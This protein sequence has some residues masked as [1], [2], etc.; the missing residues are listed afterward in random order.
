MITKYVTMGLDK[1][2]EYILAGNGVFTTYELT[3]DIAC[4]VALVIILC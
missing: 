4:L 2:L 3:R 1:V